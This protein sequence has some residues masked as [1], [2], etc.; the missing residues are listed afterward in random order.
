MKIMIVSDTHGKH[1]NLEKALQETG[2]IDLLIHLG[3]VEGAEDYI[4]AIAGC[5]VRIIAGNNDFFSDLKREDEFSLC[6]RKFFI[7]HGHYY[8]VSMG[9]ERIRMEGLDRRADVVMFGHTHRPCLEESGGIVVLNPGSISY[10]RQ[11]GR[12]ATYMTIE[13]DE[14]GRMAFQLHSVGR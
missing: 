7:T 8:Y 14:D 11:E 5:P 2:K 9:T 3:D 4:E 10:P 1:A 6:G 13:L 12:A